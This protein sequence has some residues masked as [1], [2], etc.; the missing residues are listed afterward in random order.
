M[1][2]PLTTSRLSIAPLGADDAAGF[3]AYRQDPDVARWQGWEPTY[4][5]V[6]AAQ[7]IASQP[8]SDLPD[9]GGWLQL[10]IHELGSGKLQ[11]DVAVHALTD[12]PDSV[13][14]GITVDGYAILRAEHV[15][16]SKGAVHLLS[17]TAPKYSLRVRLLGRPQHSD[18]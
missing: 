5:D 9:R 3:V 1:T 13:E 6:E 8:S 16:R 7:L 17:G 4:S 18:G 14:I 2:Y 15:S 11:G 12:L 10:A